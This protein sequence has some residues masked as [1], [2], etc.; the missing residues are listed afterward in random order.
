MNKHAVDIMKDQDYEL[1]SQYIDGELEAGQAQVLRQRLL[2]EPGLRATYDRMRGVDNRLRD[3]FAGPATQ[4]VPERISNLLNRGDSDT[5]QRRAAWGA[6]IAASVLATAGLLLNPDWRDAQ[7]GDSALAAILEVTPSGGSDWKIL[8]D[9][10]QVRPVLSFAHTDGS[11]CREYL[12]FDDGATYRG[13]ACRTGGDWVT[14]ILDTQPIPGNKSQYRPAGAD[15]ADEVAA[16]IAE[17]GAGIPLSRTE[18]AEL[19]EA[20]WH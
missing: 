8:A 19:I 7:Q 17:H 15:D 16:Y 9:G 4:Q 5:H 20:G 11:W 14:G 3:A 2:A 13:V 12:L 18:E 10:R 1:L 6:A